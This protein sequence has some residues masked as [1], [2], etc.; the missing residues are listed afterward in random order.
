[1]KLLAIETT[2]PLASVAFLTE[3]GSLREKK[4]EQKLSHLQHLIPMIGALLSDRGSDINDVTHIAVSEGPGSFTGIRIGMATAKALAQIIRVPVV[5]VPTL[6]AMARNSSD[7]PGIHCPIL[8]A[9]RNQIYAGAFLC[10]NGSPVRLL[11]DK[12]Y[13]I[14]EFADAVNRIRID[15]NKT[16]VLLGDA[17]P[18]YGE[19]LSGLLRGVIVEQKVILAEEADRHQRASSVALEAVEMIANGQ[20]TDYLAVRPVYLRKAEAQRK[21][22]ERLSSEGV[23]ETK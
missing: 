15:G 19:V 16:I 5:P 2:G 11:D 20:M 21:L 4:S 23:S 8:D 9:R 12:A 6:K 18:V 1:M 13:E 14:E 17:I 3:D 10:G 22:E 7:R